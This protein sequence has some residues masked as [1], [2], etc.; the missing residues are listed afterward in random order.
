MSI[1]R[2]ALPTVHR[3]SGTKLGIRKPRNCWIST[4]LGCINPYS[5]IVM[6]TIASSCL[7][8]ERHWFLRLKTYHDIG[9]NN[10]CCN[11]THIPDNWFSHSLTA[12]ISIPREK[13]TM[14]FINFSKWTLCLSAK[15]FGSTSGLSFFLWKCFLFSVC[16]PFSWSAAIDN[17]LWNYGENK[18]TAQTLSL[19]EGSSH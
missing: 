15:D 4:S 18:N 1:S 12:K 13:L 8:W 19:I 17:L 11:I 7:T 9:C 14:L 2:S 6:C 16:F 3:P 5:V 10:N